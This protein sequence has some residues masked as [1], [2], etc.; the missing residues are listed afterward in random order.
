VN[1]R[2]GIGTNSPAEKLHVVGNLRVTGYE[3][4]NHI[5][6]ASLTSDPP[7]AAGKMWFRSDLQRVRYSPD[8]VNVISIDPPLTAGDVWTYPNRTLTQ[9]KF[10]FW[11]AIITQNEGS[12]WVPGGTVTYVT[13]QPPSGETWDVEIAFSIGY[14]GGTQYV[15]YED[16][17][18]T[19]ARLHASNI[20]TQ[21]TDVGYIS[22]PWLVVR[23]ILTNTLYARLAYYSAGGVYGY[24][25]YS[26][27]K[28]S[29][30]LWS[31]KRLIGNPGKPWRRETDKPLPD[32][33]KPLDK[34]KAEILGLDYEK[35]DEYALGIILEED[36]PLAVDQ[37]TNFP[38]ERLTVVVK[39]DVLADLIAKFKREKADP[40]ATGYVKYIRKWLSEGIDL[41]VEL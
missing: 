11:S 36:T 38:V 18:G 16:Y 30:P 31:P 37:A 20:N 13:I 5:Y 39:A 4:P 19:T 29:K 10:P 9:T 22:H 28:L 26:G 27:F 2:L 3:N 7:L 14:A 1:K 12:I 32:I 34:Y 25:G 24:Y 23:R 17:D 40:T 41:G 21:R 35:P 8:G 33:I 6:L 15:N